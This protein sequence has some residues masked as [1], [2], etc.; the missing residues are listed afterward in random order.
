V[1]TDEKSIS[2]N[3]THTNSVNVVNFSEL[4]EKLKWILKLEDFPVGVKLIKVGDELPN[5]AEPEKSMPYCAAIARA[6]KGETILLGKNKLGC[7]FGASNLG[8][9]AVP[10][11]I[12]SGEAHVGMGLF[13]S[14]DA[15][16]KTISEIPRIT[17]ETIQATLVFP[18]E[19]A[20]MDPD[21]VILT[22]KPNNG[23]WIALSLNYITGGR[24]SSS[25]SGL[26]GTCGDVTALPYLTNKPNFTI[27]DFAG[28][29]FRAPEEIIIGLPAAMLAEVVDNLEKLCIS[30]GLCW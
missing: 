7:M 26:G 13:K 17:A 4:S 27:G 1:R 18:L 23:L 11:R 16:S 28:R 12:A 24:I 8:L 3:I 10:Q 22:V 5:I 2:D 19:K 15:A 29:K 21:V 14:T 30:S 20:P 6:R 25:F 9:I